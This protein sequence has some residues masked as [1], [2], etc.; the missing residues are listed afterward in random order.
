[1]KGIFGSKPANTPTTSNEA[2]IVSVDARLPEP[3][4]L[5]CNDDIP[6]RI[7]VKKLN[8]CAEVIYLQ[9]LQVSLIGVTKIRAHEVFRDESN[10]W[11]IVSKSN[12]GVQIGSPNDSINTETVLD[13]RLWRGQP[14]PNTV[15]PSFETCNISRTYQLDVRIGLSYG[16]VHV[17]K[18]NKKH[19]PRIV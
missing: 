4:I 17:A 7:L 2:P 9:S 6:L 10:S 18:V 5:T 19:I 12:M 3:A 14:L 1:M 8:D 16:D 15:A 13:D 11:V